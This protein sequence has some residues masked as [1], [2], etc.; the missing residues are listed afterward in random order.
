MSPRVAATTGFRALLD[1]RDHAV[2]DLE[3]GGLAAEPAVALDVLAHGQVVVFEVEGMLA[4][5]H[6]DDTHG[7]VFLQAQHEI[8]ELFGEIAERGAGRPIEGHARR[9]SRMSTPK[10]SYCMCGPFAW[11][12]SNNNA[13]SAR[14]NP[15]ARGGHARRRELW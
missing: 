1:H 11:V 9:P 3:P 12:R 7:R 4:V 6:Q 10:C 13:R 14:A 5:R 8:E 15:V 2:R